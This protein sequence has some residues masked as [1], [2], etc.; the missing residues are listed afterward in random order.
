MNDSKRCLKLPENHYGPFCLKILSE[1]KKYHKI[2]ESL[3]VPNNGK[4]LHHALSQIFDIMIHSMGPENRE[5]ILDDLDQYLMSL[6]AHF[7]KH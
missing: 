3:P 5:R 2:D 7:R 4:V 1:F 6:P